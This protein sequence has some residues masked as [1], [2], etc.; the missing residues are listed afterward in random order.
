MTSKKYAISLLPGKTFKVFSPNLRDLFFILN[1]Y[2]DK[3]F[4]GAIGIFETRTIGSLTRLS[5]PTAIAFYHLE[6]ENISELI[7]TASFD[8]NISLIDLFSIT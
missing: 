7:F 8:L 5:R 2:S 3:K 1:S 6:K 4:R